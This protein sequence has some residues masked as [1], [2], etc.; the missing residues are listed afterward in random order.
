MIPG[1]SLA[2][3]LEVF[4][5]KPFSSFRS[6]TE[7]LVVNPDGTPTKKGL[8]KTTDVTAAM[9]REGP[10][11]QQFAPPPPKMSAGLPMTVASTKTTP[12]SGYRF[13]QEQARTPPP[14]LP[15]ATSSAR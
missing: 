12:S 6:N 14:P 15:V 4:T 8:T 1:L 9:G 10:S 7:Q 5:V 11:Q 13:Q 2:K 3:A